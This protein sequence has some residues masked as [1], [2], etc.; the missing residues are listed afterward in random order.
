[1]ER[2]ISDKVFALND[3]VKL[4]VD[5]QVFNLFKHPNFG[6]PVLGYGGIPGNPSTKT[7]SGA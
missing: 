4:H 1:M 7:G 3:R 5:M 6:L 2:P